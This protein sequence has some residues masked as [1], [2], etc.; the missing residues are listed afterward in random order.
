VHSGCS[1][2]GALHFILKFEFLEASVPILCLQV[3]KF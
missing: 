2:P 1:A 3:F